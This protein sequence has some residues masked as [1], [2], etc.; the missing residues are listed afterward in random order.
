MSGDLGCSATT[1]VHNLGGLCSAN[2][3]HVQGSTAH[4]SSGTNCGTFAQKGLKNA[5]TNMGN[6]NIVGEVKQLFTNNSVEM[7]PGIKCEAESCVFNR[8]RACTADNLQITGP[9]AESSYGTRC[10]TFRE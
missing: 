10:E 5:I 2:T 7:S 9:N 8:E 1:C 4:T 3:I 6:M